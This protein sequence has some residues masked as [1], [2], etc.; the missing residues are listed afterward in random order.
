MRPDVLLL[1]EPSMFLDPRGRREL[2]RF[3]NALPGTKLIAAHDLA[4]I[5]DTCARVVVMDA[6]RVVAEG[7]SHLLHDAELMEKH[8][9]EAV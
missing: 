5:R 3:I 7:G 2:I 1:D 4:L 9:L 8:G 6:G